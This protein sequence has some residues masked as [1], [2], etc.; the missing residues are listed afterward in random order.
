M[1]AVAGATKANPIDCLLLTP[2]AFGSESGTLPV[3]EFSPGDEVKEFLT[4]ECKVLVV[5]AGGLGCEVLK[6][7]SLMGFGDIH[8]ID[9]DTIDVSNLNRQFLFRASDV[10]QPK[11]SVAAKFINARVAGAKVMPYVGRVQDRDADFYR[12]FNMVVSGLDN[13]EARR[14]LN[15]MLVSL[16]EVDD[17]GDVDPSTVI[18]MIDGGTEG[19]KG[20]A[21]VIVPRFTSCFECSL[22]SF[23]PQRTY[24]L[25]TIAETPRLP[26]HCISYAQIILWPKSFPDRKI[27]TDSPEDMQWIF[28]QAKERA[29]AY[30]ISG[31]TYMKTLGVVKNIIPAVASTNAIISGVCATE[32]FK[33]AT[34][35][36]QNLDTYMMY[37][38]SEGVYTHTFRYEKKP[39]CP[40]C[41][42]ATRD[43][44]VNPNLTLADLIKSLKA[45][46]LRLKAPSLAKADSTLYMQKPKALELATRPNLTKT[47]S[48]LVDDDDEITVTD[49]VFS[50]DVA[51]SLKLNFSLDQPTVFGDDD[52]DDDEVGGKKNA[53]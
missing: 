44:A 16:A 53:P 20:Q 38:G 49:P 21:R 47:L 14:W 1:S 27:D 36:S 46:D 42:G 11:A 51:L 4:N 29:E 31:V 13:I 28:D 10:G 45:S 43:L 17:D 5:G 35:C 6:D 3:G 15:S 40:V 2:T 33:I 30:N 34:M 52:D 37:M 18:P 22:D 26:E 12:Q 50:G 19:F 7:L 23:P 9:M 24:P 8:V 25:C 48:E 39:D 32:C 41:S